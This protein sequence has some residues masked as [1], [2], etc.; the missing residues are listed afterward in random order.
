MKGLNIMIQLI[1]VTKKD[2]TLSLKTKNSIYYITDSND[3]IIK[4]F[5]EY[6]NASNAFN[7]M[8]ES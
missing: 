1:S 5:L 2:R 6:I 3:N 7:R 8:I 4:C